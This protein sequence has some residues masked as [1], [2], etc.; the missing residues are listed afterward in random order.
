MIPPARHLVAAALSSALLLLPA[1]TGIATATAAPTSKVYA[2]PLAKTSADVKRVADYWKP[3]RLKQADRYSPATPATKAS[4]ASSSAS[5]AGSSVA[6]V[7]RSTAAQPVAPALPSQGQV[8]R[9]MGK[10]FFR[11]GD[12]EYWCSASSV[13]AKNRSVVATAGHCVYDSRQAKPADYWIFVPNPDPTGETPD[14]IYVGASISMHEDWSGKGDYDYDYAFVTVH[15]GIKWTPKNGTY[16]M[17]DVGRLQDNVGGQGLELNKKPTTYTVA[18]FGYPAGEQPDHSH[19]FDGKKLRVCPEG[20]T[21]WTSAVSADLQKGVQ[22]QPCDFSPGASGG[23]WLVGYDQTRM[24]GS[25]NGV[26]SLTWNRD[27]QGWYDAV[28]SPYFDTTTGEVYR[29]AA[30][31]T[32][33]QNVT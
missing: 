19:P 7:K 3:D 6:S 12:K 31:L 23:P 13:A 22:L 1:L 17:E 14:G 9:T 33:L 20:A 30:T 26:N 10:V 11:F 16:V 15:R 4:A 28:S 18:A 24:L 27:A 32:T 8:G 29:R 2:V 25:L 21:R 5:S